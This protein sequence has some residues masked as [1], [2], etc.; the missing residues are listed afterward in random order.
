[1]MLREQRRINTDILV[2]G[3]GGGGLRAAIAAAQ[4]G[5][6]VLLVSESPIG[7]GNNT[8]I[9]WGKMCLIVDPADSRQAYI[10]DVLSAGRFL[11]NQRLVE[12]L[13]DSSIHQVH[14]LEQLGIHFIR[15]HG[16]LEVDTAPGHSHPRWLTVDNKGLGFTLPLRVK[17]EAS[18]VKFL[19]GLFVTKLITAG[20]I[21]GAIGIDPKGVIHIIEAKTVILATGGL[22]QLYSNTTTA[23]RASGDGYALAYEIGVPLQD[24]EMVQFYPTALSLGATKSVVL[25]E[26]ALDQL[27]AIIRNREGEDV[28]AKYGLHDP[29]IRTRDRISRAMMTELVAGRG[30]NGALFLDLSNA[31]GDADK[32]KKTLPKR[33]LQCDLSKV[34]V[35]P[36][37]HF[38]MGGI[39]IDSDC[40]TEV[41]RFFAVGEV[42][43]GVHGANRLGGNSFVEIF[44]F[45]ERAGAA[46]ASEAAKQ[47][48]PGI[49]EREI[50]AERQRLHS[51]VSHTGD[52]NIEEVRKQLKN[53]MEYQA[54]II[55]NQS[56]LNEALSEIERLRLGVSRLRVEGIRDL[57][58]AVRLRNMIT[59]AEMI[60]RS[61]LLRTES[62]GAHFRTDYPEEDNEQ[63]RH[64]VVVCKEHEEM[65]VTP[66]SDFSK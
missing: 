40:R 54:G 41:A 3:G 10:N 38:Q 32:I 2:I 59:V 27:S 58:E 50:D 55:R 53:T 36:A 5:S 21:K 30:V 51:F 13:A 22:G 1:M 19:E 52:H 7:Y 4:Q 24:M 63:G 9:A 49:E 62:R 18:G 31:A 8:A 44:V 35:A 34:P 64:N 16:D 26:F 45:G 29:V 60:V 48:L 23:T 6:R 17:A 11:N 39:S 56:V 20:E 12:I 65:I 42:S 46:A 57:I 47:S 61:A 33:A 25:H 28:L 15:K 37:A 66:G 43:G 14:D